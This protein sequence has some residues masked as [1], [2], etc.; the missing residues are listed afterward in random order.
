MQFVSR[1]VTPLQLI[2]WV[3]I[4]ERRK[5]PFWNEGKVQNLACENEFYLH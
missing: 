3:G 1:Y 4:S 5:P 2:L